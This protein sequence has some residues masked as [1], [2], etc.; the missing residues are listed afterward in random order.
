M[1]KF[2]EDFKALKQALNVDKDNELCKIL[3]I[4]YS[5]IDGWKRRKKLPIKYEKYIYNKKTMNEHQRLKYIVDNSNLSLSQFALKIEANLDT[6][7]AIISGKQKIS[8]ELA[9]QIDDNYLYNPN[10][11]LYGKGNMY[12]KTSSDLTGDQTKL[13]SQYQAT[14]NTY[15]NEIIEA[16]RKL[17]YKKREY[18]Y[19]KIKS[20]VLEEEFREM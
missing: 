14:L 9:K 18:Y 3:N 6:L 16:Y 12:V 15:E 19:F 10:W 7:K 1:E 11:V 8:P 2:K 20:D 5:A 4:T 17:T 13:N